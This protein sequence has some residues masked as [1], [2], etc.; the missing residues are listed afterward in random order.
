MSPLFHLGILVVFVLPQ[1]FVDL[2]PAQAQAIDELKE[3]VV[4]ITATAAGQKRVGTGFIVKIKDKTAYILTASHVV[5]G[6][7]LVVNFFTNPDKGYKG[8]TRNMQGG[9]P[10]GLAVITVQGSLPEDI[11]SLSLA[12]N[13][14]VKGGESATVIG[15]RRSPSIQWGVLQGVL[16]GQMG[17]DLIV[18]GAGG[19]EGNSGGPILVNGKVV[20]VMTEVLDEI[21]Y[22]VPASI[23]QIVLKGWG[24]RIPSAISPPSRGVP[25]NAK[26][27][28]GKKV[29]LAQ[30]I[31]GQ[32]EVPTRL[33]PAGSAK[34]SSTGVILPGEAQKELPQGGENLDHA[35]V[36]APGTYVLKHKIRRKQVETFKLELK[37]KETLVLTWRTPLVDHAIAEAA[38]HDI[39]GAIQIR[40]KIFHKKSQVKSIQYKSHDGGTHYI[41][42]GGGNENDAGTV[43]KI[44][45]I[46]SPSSQ[47]SETSE[48]SSQ[49][50]QQT[51]SAK[52]SST[53][54]ILPGEA[55]QELSQ[56][57]ETAVPSTDI[58]N[59]TWLSANAIQGEGLGKEVSYYYTF[60]AEPGTLKITVDGKIQ[61]G[62]Y[63]NAIEVVLMDMDANRLLEINLG[64]T[65]VDKRVV[66][67][68]KIPR[69]QQL[70]LRVLLSEGTMDYKIRVEGAMNL[71]AVPPPSMDQSQ[72][73][74][75]IVTND[76]SSTNID[77]PMWLSTNAIRGEGVGEAVSYYYT[78]MAEPG[79]IKVVADG[80]IRSGSYTSALKV[81]LMDMDANQLLGI[82]LGL[83][84][85]DKRVVKRVK[86][87]RSQQLLLRV[88][89]SEGTMDYKIRV[90]G[91]VNLEAVQTGL[92]HDVNPDSLVL[93]K[94]PCILGTVHT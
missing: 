1:L 59:P 90:E 21:G 36:L 69:S 20:G 93:L 33:V 7:A 26:K 51:T 37:P 64:L 23:I 47:R 88:L 48:T 60:M 73:Q 8:T 18:S 58:D 71:E 92:I 45:I 35:I 29:D 50:A 54:V 16:T 53:G 70:L 80:K 44:S 32:D 3:G 4:K 75:M 5:E 34:T 41:S 27:S 86:I 39:V 83:T 10:K 94:N 30:E 9:N 61:S 74:A 82:D 31:T 11:R 85:I 91:A 72:H 46:K 43:Y 6:A 24:V 15:F 19:N 77:D 14:E 42:I 89:L 67:R 28:E 65:W 87:P 12:S 13:F 49:Q 62:S 79:T 57:G 81:V 76:S 78:F 84:W 52:T 55:Q 22:A 25:A 40:D 66:K 63:T 68:V 2:T 38:I 56:S 17:A